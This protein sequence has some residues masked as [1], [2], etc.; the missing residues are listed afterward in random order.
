V[1]RLE[2][3]MNQEKEMERHLLLMQLRLDI[4]KYLEREDYQVFQL[5]LRLSSSVR[6]LKEES[7]EL[8]EHVYLLLDF[9]INLYIIILS[10]TFTT[11][12]LFL[13]YIH[14]LFFI[15]FLFLLFLIKV[16]L[17]NL[18]YIEYS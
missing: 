9:H 4:I 13:F 2:L 5:L 6:L 14:F 11:I 17:T 3:S 16:Q 15:L 7:E 12:I 1:S 8:E 10:F 18:Y